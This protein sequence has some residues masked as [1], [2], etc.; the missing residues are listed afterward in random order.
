MNKL[1]AGIA[2]RDITPPLGTTL[3]GYPTVRV[4]HVVADGLAAT[5][6][7][8]R[9]DETSAAIVS[10][11]W[12]QIDEQET[13]VLRNLIAEKTCIPPHNITFCASHTHSSPATVNCWGWAVKDFNYLESARVQILAAIVEAEQALQPVRVGIGVTETDTGINRREVTPS[14]D[15]ILGFNEWGPRDRDLTVIRFEGESGPVAQIVHLSAHP[16]ARGL[17]PDI[18]RDW[19]GVMIDRVETVTQTPVLFINGSFGDVAPRTTIGGSVGD[20][21]PAALEVGLLA[22]RDAVRAFRNIKEYRDFTLETLH[23]D[24][25]LPLAPPPTLEEALDQL[26]ERSSDDKYADGE[27]GFQWNYWNAVREARVGELKTQ[28]IFSQ[29]VTSLGPVAIVPFAGEIF[30]EI[31]L[32]LKKASPFAHTLCAGLANGGQGYYVTREARGRGGFEVTVARA[33]SAYLFVDNIDDILIENNLKL[34]QQLM[35]S[36]R[37]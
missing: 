25:E 1:Q 2:R 17:D 13:A 33:Y 9:S 14:G 18:S 23:C 29:V 27:A 5:A 28:R 32:R 30:S 11:D 7:V 24:F 22:A 16:T 20:G 8:L 3:F 37:A 15:L 12:G 10:V 21:A 19:P 31:A 35:D 34:L 26:A 36:R 4:G 6:L